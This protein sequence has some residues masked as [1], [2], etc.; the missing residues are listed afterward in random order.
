MSCSPLEFL[1]CFGGTYC[2]HVQGRRYAKEATKKK[3][4]AAEDGD[5]TFVLNVGE[6][7]AYY[8]GLHP[9]R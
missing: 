1:R 2:L 9:R 4:A 8:T 5:V 6:L 7:L 3:Q